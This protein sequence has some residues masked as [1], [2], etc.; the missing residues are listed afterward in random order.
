MGN[1]INPYQNNNMQTTPYSNI[2]TNQGAYLNM[3]TGISTP[4]PSTLAPIYQSLPPSYN[5]A[6]ITSKY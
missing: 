1:Q 6:V 2:Y 4:N 3:N 5:Q